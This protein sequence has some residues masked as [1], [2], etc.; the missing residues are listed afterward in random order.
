[1]DDFIFHSSDTIHL[2]KI[3]VSLLVEPE[4]IIHCMLR[5]LFFQFFLFFVFVGKQ[6]V[7]VYL[8]V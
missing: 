8:S 3:D 5:L 4:G 1:M 6:T 2:V 7:K